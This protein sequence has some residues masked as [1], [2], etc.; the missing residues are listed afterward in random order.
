MRIRIYAG[1][2]F[3]AETGLHYN[4]HRYYD[5]KTGRYLTPDPIGLLG[6]I[7][8]FAYADNNPTNR[9]DPYG[10]LNILAGV[11]G[12]AVGVAGVEG[13]G[14]IVINPGIGRSKADA[15]VFGSVGGGLGLN[16]SADAFLGYIKGDISNVS[17]TTINQ[18]LIIGPISITSIVDINTGEFLGGTIGLGPSATLV[19]GSITGSFTGTYTIRDFLNDIRDFFDN[20]FGDPCK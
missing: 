11:G 16:V 19:G 9:L 18:N 14:G 5:P 17:G 15:G 10:L 8:L 3:D 2:Y 1:Q 4:W 12:S 7:N 6:G 20:P 13:S